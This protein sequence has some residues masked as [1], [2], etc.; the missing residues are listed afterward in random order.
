MMLSFKIFDSE[1]ASEEIVDEYAREA[2]ISFLP[3][4]SDGVEVGFSI[5]PSHLFIRLLA[6]G[7][8]TF[9]Y[10]IALSETADDN[11]AL[12]ALAE[13]ARREELALFICDVPAECIDGVA[14]L[15]THTREYFD[16]ECYAVKVISECALLDEEPELCDGVISLCALKETDIPEYSALCRD[17]MLN[18][19]WGYDYR[20]DPSAT[21]DRYFYDTAKRGFDDGAS[22]TLGVY[23]GGVLIGEGVL[24]GFD[25]MG[26]CEIAFRISQKYQGQGFGKRTMQLLLKLADDI[27]IDTIYARVDER[28][29]VSSHILSAWFEEYARQDGRIYYKKRL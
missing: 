20:D 6:D 1:A 17:V 11:E 3:A 7:E 4:V 27:E 26:G 24:W 18:K 13:Y 2:L 10:P 8:Y 5:T 28:N 25:L 14:E 22:I 12:I 16:G 19:Y 29:S 23:Y 9:V 15:F 21:S